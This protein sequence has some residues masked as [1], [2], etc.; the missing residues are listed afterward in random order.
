MQAEFGKYVDAEPAELGEVEPC[1]AVEVDPEPSAG[2]QLGDDRGDSAAVVDARVAFAC[3]DGEGDVVDAEKGVDASASAAWTQPGSP[4]V[5]SV[6]GDDPGAAASNA[7]W[8]AAASVVFAVANGVPGLTSAG[9]V[10][11]GR[12]GDMVESGKVVSG[13][14][15][16]PSARLA[17]V[18]CSCPLVQLAAPCSPSEFDYR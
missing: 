3:T 4:G 13:S 6:R 5:A 18:R 17:S 9:L 10:A 16:L 2:Y 11:A 14:R 12:A 8:S 1:F 7:G 15:S